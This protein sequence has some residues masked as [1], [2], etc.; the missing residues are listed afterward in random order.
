MPPAIRWVVPA[1]LAVAGLL[2]AAGVFYVGWPLPPTERCSGDVCESSALSVDWDRVDWGIPPERISCKELNPGPRAKL[3]TPGEVCVVVRGDVEL[4]RQTYDELREEG[5][6]RRLR[7]LAGV[8][9]A[10]GVT[11]AVTTAALLASRRA[12]DARPR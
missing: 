3:M 2:V 7:T 5:A 12:A 9:L 11:V 10:L 1:T 4:S 8:L 6:R